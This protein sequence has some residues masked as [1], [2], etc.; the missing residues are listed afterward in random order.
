MA[1]L[2]R[3]LQAYY[4]VLEIM[5]STS[6]NANNKIWFFFTHFSFVLA[7]FAFV[8]IFFSVTPRLLSNSSPF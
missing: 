4:I 8:F 5:Y 1:Y 2:D 7:Y 6:E 3:D